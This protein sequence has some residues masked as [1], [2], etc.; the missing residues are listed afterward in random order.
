VQIVDSFRGGF[1]V[2]PGFECSVRFEGSNVLEVHNLVVR[3]VSYRAVTCSVL[4][5]VEPEPLAIAQQQ[6]GIRKLVRLGIAQPPLPYYLANLPSLCQNS[7]D[8]VNPDPS[9]GE[10]RASSGE[11]ER[12]RGR[13]AKRKQRDEEDEREQEADAETDEQADNQHR[14]SPTTSRASREYGI[15]QMG[16][17]RR[18]V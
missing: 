11:G 8:L 17:K 12:E 9:T 4:D 15:V 1:D 7:F 18:G 3:V 2:G 6:Q 5:V 14:P 10:Q 16:E 13:K